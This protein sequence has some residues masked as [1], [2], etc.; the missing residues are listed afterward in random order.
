MNWD[1]REERQKIIR[2]IT[3][4]GFS[5]IDAKIPGRAWEPY[6]KKQVLDRIA[7]VWDENPELRLGQLIAGIYHDINDLHHVEDFELAGNVE[8]FHE[9]RK[10]L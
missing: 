2:E 3:G 1:D 6:M 5:R 7:A 9:H 4:K 8:A 10:T